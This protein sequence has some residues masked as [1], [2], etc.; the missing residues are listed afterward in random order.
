ME[1]SS[2]KRVSL[3][4]NVLFD[5]ALERDFAH[6]LREGCQRKGY[7]LSIV[8]SVVAELYFFLEHGDDIQER[9]AR[10]SISN[11][12]C[13]DIQA[14]PLTAAQLRTAR[15]FARKIRIAGLLAMAEANDACILA[16]SA[17]AAIPLVVSSDN[18]ILNIDDQK[19]RTAF[20]DAGMNPVFAV[21]PRGLAR[22]LR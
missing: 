21:S 10:I 20:L 2:Q 17:I 3:D 14:T 15:D 11:L 13:W 16:E 22:A 5:L 4:T 6:D 12:A 18:H 7:A 1:G 8:P 9:C 19:L